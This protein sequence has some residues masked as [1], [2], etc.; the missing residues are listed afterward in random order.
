MKARRAARKTI[1]VGALFAA[2]CAHAPQQP[3]AAALPPTVESFFDK[4]RWRDLRAAAQLIVADRRPDF[5]KAAAK[6]QDDRD[7][8]LT[9]F[10]AEDVRFSA[11]GRKATVLVHV[12]WVRLP[13]ATEQSEE[14]TSEFVWDAGA[15]WLA[16]Q[17]SGPFGEELS[18]PYSTP[19]ADAGA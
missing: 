8:T 12:R 1:L 5:L 6:R 3:D 7:L 17:E 13:S 16:R 9:E 11:D 10:T 2:A 14:V 15:W 19:S 18:A 4:V